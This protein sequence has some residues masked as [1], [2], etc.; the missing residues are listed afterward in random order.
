MS[1]LFIKY[2]IFKYLYY[3]NKKRTN[4][5]LI[6]EKYI[7]YG[8]SFNP[9]HVG[10]FSAIRQMLEEYEH[11][12]V[13]P[14]PKKYSNGIAEDLP[15]I[16]QRLQMLDLFFAEF[17]PQI[18]DRLQLIDLATPLMK[19]KFV[20]GI[21]H[22]IDYLEYAKQEF[23]KQ[24]N[25]PINLS[26]CL[27]FDENNIIRKESFHK[28]DEIKDKFEVFTLEEENNIESKKL[29]EFF[30]KNK[31]ITSAKQE[32][33]IRSTV[34]NNL[35]EYILKNNLYGMESPKKNIIKNKI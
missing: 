14:Y 20:K 11:V 13:F 32:R 2:C 8:A 18:N 24:L 34:G 35:T 19:S 1:I 28:Q 10:H 5:S 17:F 12:I 25:K 30:A 31:K 27:G 21:P 26:I 7:L 23:E 3:N 33:Y 29:R 9:P 22:T 4:M 6:I 15:P 16:T